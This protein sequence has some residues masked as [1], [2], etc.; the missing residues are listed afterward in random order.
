[1][2]CIVYMWVLPNHIILGVTNIEVIHLWGGLNVPFFIL[3]CLIEWIYCTVAICFKGSQLAKYFRILYKSISGK[4]NACLWQKTLQEKNDFG[5]FLTN[6]VKQIYIPKYVN[7]RAIINLIHFRYC[8][9][10]FFALP[11]FCPCFLTAFS[12]LHFSLYPIFFLLPHHV[13]H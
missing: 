3:M 11:F 9:L 2:A 8:S 10:S 7:F 6:I 4:L 13:S 12:T 1:M 5:H